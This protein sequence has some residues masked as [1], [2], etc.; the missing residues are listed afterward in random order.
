MFYS[1]IKNIEALLD[2]ALI[3]DRFAV[4]R[5]LQRLKHRLA[6]GLPPKNAE[7]QLERFGR[8]LKGSAVRRKRRAAAQPRLSFDP[9]LPITERMDDIVS[10]IRKHPVVI[11]SGE[12]GS[13]KTTQIP[14][15]CLAAGRGID[16]RIGC[17]QPRR[18]AATSVAH[19]IAEEM[20]ETVGRS[21]GY[22][23]RFQD[24]TPPEALIK[25]MTDGILLTEVQRDRHLTEY[26]TII[27]DEAHERS[28]NIDFILGVLKMLLRRRRDLKL[29]VTSATIDT[30]KFSRAFDDAPVIE[31]S[32]RMFPVEVVYYPDDPAWRG[33]TE[34]DADEATH[35]DMAVAAVRKL[36][37]TGPFGDILVFM[38]T[39]QDIRD[40]CD[41]LEGEELGSRVMPL[42]AR[43]PAAEQARVFSRNAGRKIIVATNVAETSLTIP[44]IR[45]VVDTGLARISH[46]NP[47]SRTT[48]LPVVPVSRSSA[49]Q[50]KGRCGR[51][52]NGVCIRLF[53]EED[54]LA[55]PLYTP[56]E[57]LRSNLAEVILRMTALRLGDMAVFPFIDPPAPK[58]IH[59][60]RDVLVELG[61]IEEKKAALGG[62][63]DR[64]AKNTGP[65]PN[66]REAS[67]AQKGEADL[68]HDR[69]TT[70]ELT[71]R[72]TLMARL[73]VDPLLARMLIEAGQLGCLEEI[74]VIAAALSIPDPRER[75]ADRAGDADRA[76]EEFVEPRSD[77][78]TLLNLWNRYHD[79][80][81]RVKTTSQ[82]KKY[83]R[84]HFLSFRRM[85]EWRDIYNQLGDILAENGLQQAEALPV[86]DEDRY[87]AIHRSILSGLLANIA[88]RKEKNIF[89]A[90]KGREVMV[91]P[92][93]A[94]FNRPGEWIV[95]AEMVETSRLFARAAANIDVGWL[96]E[97]GGS[98]CR[99]TFLN[100]RWDSRRGEVVATQ[101][102]SLFGLVIVPGRTV[103]FGRIDPQTAAEVFVRS[104]LVNGE[105]ESAFEFM[106]HNDQ[107]VRDIKDMENRLRR[108]DILVDDEVMFRFFMQRLP[109]V[110]DLRRLKRLIRKRGG[111]GFLRMSPEE[112]MNYQ[113]ESGRL[114]LY[115]ECVEW[116]GGQYGC[117]YSF[118]PGRPEDGLTV[119][120][121]SA[122]APTLP[123]GAADWMVPGF[124]GEKIEAL[125]K[126]L[127]K[128]YRK[129]LVPVGRTVEIILKEMPRSDGALISALG[130][131]IFQRFGIDIPSTAWSTDDLPEHLA[132]R[133]AITDPGGGII[134]SSRDPQI[135]RRLPR[136]EATPDGWETARRK[137]EKAGITQWDFG[138]LPDSIDLEVRGGG[139]WP[140]FPGLAVVEDSS[141]SRIDLRLYQN[142]QDA[143]DA[144]VAGVAALYRLHF[145]KDLTFLR[146]S[147]MLPPNRSA[148]ARAFGGIR[149]LEK[150][151][152]ETVVSRLFRRNIRSREAFL[153]EAE[154][155]SQRILPCGREFIE[156]I[157]PVIDACHD[158]LTT[159]LQ[160][161]KANRSNRFLLD[162]LG[163]CREEMVRL[164]P[165]NFM[166]IY[167]LER[168]EHLPR[169]VA[170]IDIRVRR[171][172]VNFEKDQQKAAGLQPF[173]AGLQ[174]LVNT[175]SPAVSPEKRAALEDFFWLL[176]EFKVSLF[177]QELKTAVPV[178]E[179]R[180]QDTM[181]EIERMV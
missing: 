78:L 115:P 82:M 59:D 67:R 119:N 47:R 165:E 18:I 36:R 87:A 33:L 14:K 135:L 102:V 66:G 98:L 6:G 149:S 138:D 136:N 77:F 19:R 181:D 166:L 20:E 142:G 179:K 42:F 107:T 108:R 134:H 50:R 9:S 89:H 114:S 63:G 93:S 152:Y 27:V 10:A 137:W 85:R 64:K 96:E 168:M 169:Y 174:R 162:F 80:W 133:I 145:S 172:S 122:A 34:G 38:P 146:K 72:G 88:V 131:F 49:D 132:V 112:L 7:D 28:L 65:H 32:G 60:G 12:T 90:A 70:F 76:Q 164:V 35:V 22:K 2:E 147:L 125:L 73:P 177:A 69:S 148:A 23:I 16:G 178:S 99:S 140:V 151:I 150:R 118:N 52:Q 106:R 81:R 62:R 175:L 171:A 79:T 1:E 37:Q 159:I 109:G 127:P 57:I 157:L 75:P 116:G 104:A 113:P 56:P 17:T 61:A 55:R 31:V 40:T 21:V 54:Y 46:Y 71:Q 167:S 128:R 84:A 41:I 173:S 180:L 91:F 170:A 26:D 15:F 154:S 3:A 92:G 44:G 68:P 105:M 120:I 45:Y 156:K 51:V 110:Y 5:Q 143:A 25:I 155:L 160:L 48:A 111:D 129:Q 58:S 161:E 101:Q 117:S 30:D 139:S 53:S 11:V 4:R 121:P 124:L 24:R 29:I 103:S 123:V 126:R 97:L 144:H 130:K 153:A 83:C 43:L 141:G 94:L 8:Q 13:G 39:E 100:P 158:T 74:T 176:E 86:P 95:A 163:R